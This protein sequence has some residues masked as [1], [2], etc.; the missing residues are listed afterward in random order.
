MI[1]NVQANSRGIN[2][3]F[4]KTRKSVAKGRKGFITK[5][6]NKYTKSKKKSALFCTS[7]VIKIST[8][9]YIVSLHAEND[10]IT[11]VVDAYGC[12]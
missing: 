7:I 12:Q 4:K 11:C 1:T 9:K 10:F 2:F 5:D 6:D 8:C 3:T